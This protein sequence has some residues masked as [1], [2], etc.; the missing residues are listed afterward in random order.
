[1]LE[2]DTTN[3]A[4]LQ[5]FGK[6]L[7]GGGLSNAVF[8]RADEHTTAAGDVAGDAGL[9]QKLLQVW[10]CFVADTFKRLLNVSSFVTPFRSC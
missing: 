7:S 8:V 1:M 5:E 3:A 6:H 10:C 9:D 4:V 2:G